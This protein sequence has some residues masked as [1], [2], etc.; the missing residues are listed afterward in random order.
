MQ[1]HVIN[2]LTVAV[3]GLWDLDHSR[4]RI[5]VKPLETRYSGLGMNGEYPLRA[6]LCLLEGR[7]VLN[8]SVEVGTNPVTLTLPTTFWRMLVIS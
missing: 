1:Q 4:H 3:K 2:Q 8:P 7:P 6:K 5:I